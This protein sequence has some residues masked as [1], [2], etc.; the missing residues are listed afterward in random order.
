MYPLAASKRCCWVQLHPESARQS[1]GADGGEGGA[2]LGAGSAT[3]VPA[4]GPVRAAWVR[5]FGAAGGSTPA[6]AQPATPRIAQAR[7]GTRQRRMVGRDRLDVM[8]G[9]YYPRAG[10]GMGPR[11]AAAKAHTHRMMMFSSTVSTME[12]STENR[13]IMRQPAAPPRGRMF[14]RVTPVPQ[15][16]P[17]G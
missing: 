5:P 4:V 13:I 16:C 1:A 3:C 6:R 9:R 10:P 15:R 11:H 17:V 12:A 14:M 7:I 8:A 2:A